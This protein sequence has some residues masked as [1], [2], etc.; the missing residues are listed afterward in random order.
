MV[1]KQGWNVKPIGEFL[2]GKRAEEWTWG[3]VPAIRNWGQREYVTTQVFSGMVR[4]GEG[5]MEKIEGTADFTLTQRKEGKINPDGQF[6]FNQRYFTLTME[7]TFRPIR[8]N[9][10]LP[11]EKERARTFNSRTQLNDVVI[12][13]KYDPRTYSIQWAGDPAIGVG[14]PFKSTFTLNLA[15][16]PEFLKDNQ[17]RLGVVIFPGKNLLGPF[18]KLLICYYRALLE[19]PR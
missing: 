8:V 17:N 16:T 4:N 9:K 11:L 13:K 18:P 12:V 19:D 1:L 6:V 15:S 3:I 2:F 7:S 10:D 14:D 5:I